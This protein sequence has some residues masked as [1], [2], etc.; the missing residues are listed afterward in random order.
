VSNRLDIAFATAEVSGVTGQGVDLTIPEGEIWQPM[1][2]SAEYELAL[3]TADDTCISAGIQKL[4]TGYYVAMAHSTPVQ[5]YPGAAAGFIVASG[6]IP[7][8]FLLDGRWQ[9]HAQVDSAAQ[10]TVRTMTLQVL[11]A[12]L[13]D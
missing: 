11:Y 5:N 4:G 9:F 10:T 1:A 13:T 12:K 7:T 8:R 2:F 6:V 3:T